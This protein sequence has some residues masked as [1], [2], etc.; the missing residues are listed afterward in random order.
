[1]P[2]MAQK[3]TGV[4]VDDNDGEYIPYASAVYRGNH[5]MVSSD[6]QGKFSIDR[7]NGWKLTFSAVGYQPLTIEVSEKTK[8]PMR[9]TLKPEKNQLENVTVRGKRNRYSRKDNPAVELMRRV[10]AAKKKTHLDNH[11]FYQYN[12]YCSRL[13]A[14]MTRTPRSRSRTRSFCLS[15]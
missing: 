6:A 4:I 5:V 11:D 12:K 10:I 7:H 3:L 14:R 8:S 1:M 13:K 15:Q 2:L 9:I